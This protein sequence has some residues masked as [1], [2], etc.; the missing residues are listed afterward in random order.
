MATYRINDKRHNKFFGDEEGLPYDG[1][2][3]KVEPFYD[4]DPDGLLKERQ[5][6][7]KERLVQYFDWS[8][9]F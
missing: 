1:Y 5:R 9:L 2:R 7:K 4:T 6:K 8:I 3:I